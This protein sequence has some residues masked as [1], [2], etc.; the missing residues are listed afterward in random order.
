M[1]LYRNIGQHVFT[2]WGLIVD[3]FHF[4]RVIALH[5]V[6]ICSFLTILLSK[7]ASYMMFYYD[8]QYSNILFILEPLNWY[9]LMFMI[10]QSY[11]YWATWC[12]SIKTSTC[13]NM[14]MYEVSFYYSL[15]LLDSYGVLL[16]ASNVSNSSS[17][18]NVYIIFL[19]TVYR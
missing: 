8:K 11:F 5:L 15:Q 17:P 9:F 2:L 18:G 14:Q 4:C 10:I 6:K 1:K 13:S 3:L 16:S 7:F 19:S 12:F